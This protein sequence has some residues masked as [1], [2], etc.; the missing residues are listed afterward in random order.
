MTDEELSRRI[1]RRKA[2]RRRQQAKRRMRNRALIIGTG[3][4]LLVIIIWIIVAICGGCSSKTAENNNTAAGSVSSIDATNPVESAAAAPTQ[5]PTVKEI[6]DDGTD[7]ELTDGGIYIWKNKGFEMFY[8]SEDTAKNYAQTIS[9]CKEALGS[10]ITVYNMVIPVS[11]EYGLPER[12]KNSTGTESEK[13]FIDSI[14][15][16]YSGNVK[17]VYIYDVLNQH[18]TEY[19]YFN[20][21]HHW[22]GLGAYYAYTSFAETAG[23]APNDINSFTSHNISGFLGSFYTATESD[24]LQSNPDTVTYYD[25]PG[26]YTVKILMDGQDEFTEVDSINYGAADSGVD[27]YSA[28]IWGDNPVMQI[29]HNK[30]DSNR[31]I[32]VVKESFGNAFIPF[33]VNNYDEVHAIDFRYYEGNIKDYCTKNGITEVLFANGVISASNSFQVESIS[34]LLDN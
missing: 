12:L 24:D 10:D 16:N 32:L 11:T 21:D 9:S 26:D 14:Y 4:L 23:F 17:P 6:E 13:A 19:I 8:G 25:I 31:K 15:K 33:L 3:I 29:V 7:G 22:T 27:T 2:Y 5:A 34:A 18:K 20:T 1:A 28:F 30:S